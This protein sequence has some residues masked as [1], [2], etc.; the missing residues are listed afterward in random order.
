MA[1]KKAQPYKHLPLYLVIRGSRVQ[2]SR[3][4]KWLSQS[5]IEAYTSPKEVK[6]KY[7]EHKLS[8]ETILERRWDLRIEK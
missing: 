2:D 4:G 6:T 3:T 5:E 7:K 8:H 1:K